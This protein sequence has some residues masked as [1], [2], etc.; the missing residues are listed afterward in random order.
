MNGG[1]TKMSVVANRVVATK[2]VLEWQPSEEQEQAAVMQWREIMLPQFP[3][4]KDLIHIPNGGL[5]SKTE[6]VRFKKLGVKAG[7]SDLFLPVAR[8]GFHGLWI[9]MKRKRGG[10]LSPDQKE[11]IEDMLSNGYQALRADGAEEACDIIF[12]YLTEVEQ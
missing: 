1:P 11:W 8:G 10:K 4:L 3:E 7:V 12:K 6:A 5:R 2:A 9:E